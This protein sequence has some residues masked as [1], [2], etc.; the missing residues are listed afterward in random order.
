MKMEKSRNL[1]RLSLAALSAA[2]ILFSCSKEEE[3][4]TYLMDGS[5]QLE[6][7]AY[8]AYGEYLTLS[9]GG[10]Q[11]PENPDYLWYVPI[12]YTD[13]LKGKM[14][15]LQFPDS[16]KSFTVSVTAKYKGFYE[17]YASTTVTSIDTSASGSFQGTAPGDGVIFDDRDGQSYSY[18]TIGKLDW[19]SQNL[20]YTG[21]GVPYL[22]SPVTHSIFGR[23]YSWE[24]A[25]GGED[26]TGLGCGPQGV[27][28]PGWS[29]PTNEDWEDLGRTLSGN[30][31]LTFYDDWD[32]A[33]EM[34]SADATFINEKMWSYNP[35]NGH[36]N[37]T[38]WN[39]IP[40]GYT[41]SGHA[42]FE[43]FGSYGFW[44]SSGT[45]N[46]GQAYYR[47]QHSDITGFPMASTF[48]KGIGASVRCVR[49]SQTPKQS[50]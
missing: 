32:D 39:A 41:Q 24:E 20:A 30:E 6:C 13:S 35:D 4:T 42:S 29:V 11:V 26:G 2:L 17:S 18:V 37:T 21:A 28:P 38:G 49:L 9:T 19:F 12:M 27:C 33:A 25:T 1:I 23:F 10:I 40:A 5:V 31:A 45:R 48:K 15:T 14:V 22:K 50:L 44:W 46:D 3:A 47:Y 36:T 16:T 7:P 34:M 43:G 8:V